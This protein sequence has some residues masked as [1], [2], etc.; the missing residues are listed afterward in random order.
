MIIRAFGQYW[1]PEIVSWGKKGPG[2]QGKLVGKVKIDTLTYNIDFWNAIGIYILHDSFRP[3]Y[4]GKAFGTK[5]GPRLRD[6]LTDRFAG[7][8]DMFSWF[9]L[10][11]INTT[12][13]STRDPGTRQLSPTT[14]TDTLEALAILATDAPL[15]RRRESI[16]S[17]IEAIQPKGDPRTVRNYLEALLFET[18]T[19]R[20]QVDQ[21]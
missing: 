8:W 19:I 3:I 15:N 11:T 17:A 12:T 5:I 21:L 20:E 14:V 16:P 1:N 7:R 2:N 6:H 18:T 9:T 13:C 4:V 10:S